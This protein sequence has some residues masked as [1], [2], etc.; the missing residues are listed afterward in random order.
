MDAVMLGID[1]QRR[2]DAS[3]QFG[4]FR[5]D[6]RERRLLKN[7]KRL[8]LTPKAFQ[9]LVVLVSHRGHLV[10]KDDLLKAIWPDR[11]VEESSLAR[12]I[13]VLRKVLQDTSR[14]PRFIETVAKHGYRFVGALS[15]PVELHGATKPG[16]APTV[17]VLPFTPVAPEQGEP[18]LGLGLADSLITRLS[19]LQ[20]L[21]IRPTSAVRKYAVRHNC[22][23]AGRALRVEWVVDGCTRVSGDRLRVTVQLVNVDNGATAWAEKFDGTLDDVFGVE[24]AIAERVASALADRLSA[25][26]RS[27]LSKRH[28]GSPEAHR[29]YLM[30]RYYWNR[31]TEESLRQAIDCFTRALASDPGYALAYAGLADAY[32]LLGSYSYGAVHPR[33][34]TPLARAAAARALE[35]DEELAEPTTSLA[36]I[37]FRYDWNWPEADR[38]L[39]RAIEL[40]P[41]YATARQ[42]YAFLLAIQGRHDDALLEIQRAQELDP[43]SLPIATGVGRLLYFAGRYPEAIEECRRAI[44][45]DPAFA[46]AH[47]DLGIVYE[48]V[49]QYDAAIAEFREAFRLSA[50]SP[51][52]L[53]QLGHAYGRS[54]NTSAARSVVNQLVDLSTRLYVA[55]FDWAIV[56][57]GLGEIDKALERLSEAWHERSS[58]LVFLKA[59]RS[60]APLYNDARFQALLRQMGLPATGDAD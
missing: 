12:N 9:T 38:L 52:V 37:K 34:V 49:N 40:N 8:A 29:W 42:W 39:R 20:R 6:A 5:L 50:G 53:T 13:S 31:R 26:D 14:K 60:F 46:G 33:D 18:F 16:L 32:T 44:A 11:Y 1:T 22:L 59:D 43:L 23:S 41:H 21:I 17:A 30:G 57:A 10:S 7:G 55:P 27:R 51:V 36:F 24:D 45:L 3:C 58:S 4:P 2:A 54:G 15:E 47:L 19:R 25:A 28:T 35:I 48:Q 56:H